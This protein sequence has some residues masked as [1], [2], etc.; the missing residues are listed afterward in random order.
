MHR[1]LGVRIKLGF[2][3]QNVIVNEILIWIRTGVQTL[4]APNCE[5]P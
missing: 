1:V 2:S 5:R 4:D 3:N